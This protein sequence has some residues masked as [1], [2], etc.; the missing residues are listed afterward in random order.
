MGGATGEKIVCHKL[1]AAEIMIRILIISS[2]IHPNVTT[3][4]ESSSA[5]EFLF[6]RDSLL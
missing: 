4:V 6:P 2:L 1:M 3:L 5:K